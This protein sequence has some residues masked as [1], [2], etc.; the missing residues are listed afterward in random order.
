MAHNEELEQAAAQ[1]Q[2]LLAALWRLQSYWLEIDLT[3]AQTRAFLLICNAGSIHGRGLAR[4]LGIGQPAVSKLVDH[5]VA[6]G[7]VVRQEDPDD[8]RIV[9]LTPSEE[10]HALFE[11]LSLSKREILKAILHRLSPEELERAAGLFR[12]MAR[13]AEELSTHIH[14]EERG[15][16]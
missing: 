2:A 9:W 1:F 5:L 16:C 14:S 13:S 10:G 4:T 3:M 7:L 15:P 6:K 11:R 12:L 8:R